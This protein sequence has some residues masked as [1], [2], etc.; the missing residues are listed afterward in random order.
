MPTDTELLNY[1]ID[2]AVEVNVSIKLPGRAS[3][4]GG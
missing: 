2:S 1:L 4:H 3:E